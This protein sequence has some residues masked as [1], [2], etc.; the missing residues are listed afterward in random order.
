LRILICNT[1]SRIKTLIRV[2]IFALKTTPKIPLKAA[3]TR[4]DAG[5]GLAELPMVRENQVRILM[6]KP[7]AKI[8]REAYRDAVNTIKNSLVSLV[9]RTVQVSNVSTS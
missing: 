4:S 2:R 5:I 6:I 1:T 3:D 7:R 9:L 8:I